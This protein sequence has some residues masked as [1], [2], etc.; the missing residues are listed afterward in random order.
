MSNELRSCRF[1]LASRAERPT[2]VTTPKG[3]R[4]IV[5]QPNACANNSPKPNRKDPI[6]FSRRHYRAH[7]CVK[8]C[9]NKITHDRRIAKRYDKSAKSFLPA[10]KVAA[11]SI[12]L[13][14]NETKSRPCINSR[15]VHHR[16]ICA[17]IRKFALW[18][19]YIKKILLGHA[20]L[21]HCF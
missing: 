16:F 17:L 7:N 3:P 1:F 19:S 4:E 2:R 6:C 5:A 12:W 14:D 21:H 8:R 15:S 9:F 13:R 18:V 11:T 10:L 20:R